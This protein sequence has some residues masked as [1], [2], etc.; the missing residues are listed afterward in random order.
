MN[1]SDLIKIA[2]LACGQKIAGDD[3]PMN[4]PVGQN[5]Y[6]DALHAAHGLGRAR[7]NPKMLA[8]VGG[9]DKA[10]MYGAKLEDSFKTEFKPSMGDLHR[11]EGGQAPRIPFKTAELGKGRRK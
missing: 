2:E 4:P 1:N 6:R 7:E 8:R 5:E 11:A 3:P 10:K 9:D